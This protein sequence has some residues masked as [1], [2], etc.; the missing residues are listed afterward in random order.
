MTPTTLSQLRAFRPERQGPALVAVGLAILIVAAWWPA[1]PTTTAMALVA[2]GAT[3]ATLVRFQG[4]STIVVAHA[5]VYVMLYTLFF[6]AACHAMAM[7]T[8]ADAH[9]VLDLAVSIWPMT[10]AIALSLAAV[11]R[12]CGTS[13]DP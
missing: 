3:H 2:L 11:G 10:M 1:A 4:S 9:R 7:R 5:I 13:G 12:D 6:G 8:G